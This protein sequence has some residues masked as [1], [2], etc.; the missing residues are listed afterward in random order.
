[1][2]LIIISDKEKPVECLHVNKFHGSKPS[3]IEIKYPTNK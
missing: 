3:I 2:K 1:M